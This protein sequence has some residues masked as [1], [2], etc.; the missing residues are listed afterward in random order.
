MVVTVCAVSAMILRVIINY[1][2]YKAEHEF[3]VNEKTL[4]AGYVVAS[5]V[6]QFIINA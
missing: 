5:L 4:L 2:K 6:V 3:P 1:P